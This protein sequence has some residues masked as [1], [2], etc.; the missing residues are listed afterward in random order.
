[1]AK[2]NQRN[3]LGSLTDFQS[4]PQPTPETTDERIDRLE[5][6]ILQVETLLNDVNAPARQ[7]QHATEIKNEW[8]TKGSEIQASH[9]ETEEG[10]TE[11]NSTE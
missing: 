11:E 2:H 9:T 7:A 1:M 10:K 4:A 5:R 6:R 8:E 3:T